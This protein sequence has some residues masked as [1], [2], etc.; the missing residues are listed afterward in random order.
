MRGFASIDKMESCLIKWR[1]VEEE[2]LKPIPGLQDTYTD[3]CI[4]HTWV[5]VGTHTFDH[6]YIT[7]N[8]TDTS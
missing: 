1:I 2:F 3:T 4:L 8:N 5:C 7:S 6:T